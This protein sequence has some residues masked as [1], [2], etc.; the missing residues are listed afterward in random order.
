LSAAADTAVRASA[1]RASA[2]RPEHPEP[3]LP[4]HKKKRGER[5]AAEAAVA[6]LLGTGLKSER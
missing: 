5:N 6:R 2:A 4:A 1:A 3:F